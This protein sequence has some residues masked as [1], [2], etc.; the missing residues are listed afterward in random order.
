MEKTKENTLEVTMT[1]NIQEECASPSV[2]DGTAAQTV[3]VAE[4][5]E[6]RK[7]IQRRYSAVDY[8]AIGL[9]LAAMVADRF[10]GDG[11]AFWVLSAVAVAAFLLPPAVQKVRQR[12]TFDLAAVVRILKAAGLE[13]RIAVDEVRWIS[14]GKENIVRIYEGGLLQLLREYPVSG[15]KVEIN[16][17]AAMYTMREVCSVKVGIRREGDDQGSLIFSSESL[18]PSGRLFKQVFPEYVQALDIAEM[19]QGVHFSEVA[20]AAPTRKRIGF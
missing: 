18:C 3:S 5:Q 11:W 13:P 1:E 10:V 6:K 14:N 2:Q 4:S 19:R 9:C 17:R 15:G 7:S 20:E 12:A 8:V 16:E